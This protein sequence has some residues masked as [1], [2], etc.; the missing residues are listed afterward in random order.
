M[1]R[2]I[3]QGFFSIFVKIIGFFCF[4][5]YLLAFE[6][7]IQLRFLGQSNR[8]DNTFSIIFLLF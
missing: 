4:P 2:L 1:L 7:L 8:L 6:R 3:M 5:V